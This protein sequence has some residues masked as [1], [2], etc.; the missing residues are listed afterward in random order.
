MQLKKILLAGKNRKG[1]T[2]RRGCFIGFGVV[3][4]ELTHRGMS[5]QC[6]R[7]HDALHEVVGSVGWSIE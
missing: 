6:H 3:T 7:P 4:I 2:G 5:K 1:Y